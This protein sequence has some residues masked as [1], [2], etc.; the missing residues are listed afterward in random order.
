MNNEKHAELPCKKKKKI[1]IY[2]VTLNF[3]IFF[4]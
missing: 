2:E 3:F 1:H 4:N